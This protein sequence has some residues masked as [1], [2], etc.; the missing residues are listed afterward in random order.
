MV[1][2]VNHVF[3]SQVTSSGKRSLNNASEKIYKDFRLC[4]LF[5]II[6]A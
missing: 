4:E 6:E 2:H 3:R 5:E 1:E